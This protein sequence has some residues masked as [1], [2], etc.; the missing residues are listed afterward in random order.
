MALAPVNVT[1]VIDRESYSIVEI[2]PQTSGMVIKHKESL[3]EQVNLKVNMC[4]HAV[5]CNSILLP[6][7][8]GYARTASNTA[9]TSA[10][11]C[12][13]LSTVKRSNF[14]SACLGTDMLFKKL[15]FPFGDG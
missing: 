15:Y 13:L 3:L 4:I 11:S 5:I 2:P 7:I 9:E 6:A 14:S 10:G 1:I 12:V 8:F